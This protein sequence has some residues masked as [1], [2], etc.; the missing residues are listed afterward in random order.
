MIGDCVWF[1][2]VF[3]FWLVWFVCCVGGFVG[4]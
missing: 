3:G 4:C 2:F 1:V